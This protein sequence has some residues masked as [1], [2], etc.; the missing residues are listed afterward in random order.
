MRVAQNLL[1]KTVVDATPKAF[2]ECYLFVGAD[3]I[4]FVLLSA[5]DCVFPLLGYS[6]TDVFVT[7][8]M[9]E[10]ITSWIDGYQREIASVKAIGG[11][12]SSEVTREWNRLLQGGPKGRIEDTYV[13]PLLSSSWNQTRPYNNWCPEDAGNEDG[14]A[15]TG[16]VATATA[17]VMYYW[18]HPVQG[19]RSHSYMSQTYGELGVNYDTSFYDWDNMRNSVTVW[20]GQASV[21]AVAKLCY[22]VGV[23]MDMSYSAASSGA[24]EHSGGMLKRRSAQQGL[25]EH[26]YYN[27]GM[28]A[29]FKEGYTDAEWDTI[30][31]NELNAERPIIYTGSSSTG[32][33]AF[34][35][36]GYDPEGLFH[37]NWGW[38][39]S[40]N[41]YYTLNHLAVG[42]EGQQGYMAF[43]EL[44]G[45][46]LHCYPITP[47]DS[48]SVVSVVSSD[49]ARGS[50][51][52]SGIYPV[53]SDRVL[54]Y[55]TAADGYRF[56][57]W[58]SG[59]RNNPIMFFPTI[60]YSDTAYF[61]PLRTDSLGYCHNYAPN[62]DTLYSL[63]HCE[64]GI[65]IPADHLPAGKEL[66]QVMD[67]VYTTGNYILKI[68]RGE[69]PV[70]PVYEDT[71]LL[72]SYGWRT[73][74]LAT[75]VALDGDQPLWIT[76]ITEN[77]K[78]P[79]GIS[80]NSGVADGSWIKHDGNW[81]PMDTTD[82]GYYTWSILGLLRSPSGIESVVGDG[83][84]YTLDGLTLSIDNPSRRTVSLYDVSGRK[85]MALS[86]ERSTFTLPAPG[87][88]LIQADGLPAR[89]IVAVQR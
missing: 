57:H 32:G 72:T 68:Y 30:I 69:R 76:F 41:G 13:G 81:E 43:N 19:R 17:Q 85:H 74:D 39:G 62:F 66:A 55:A 35:I 28:F 52:G 27:P 83:L 80:P 8:N 23:I 3:G 36:D 84:V 31:S 1:Q 42:Q 88:Y 86:A 45:A 64:W 4:G 47:N 65:R 75:P 70:T 51:R 34:V 22:E 56:D 33:H 50:V 60:D 82:L 73:I 89:R 11:L 5:D 49:P 29:D 12:V 9:P 87:F 67:F 77:V 44:N 59:N 25:A 54:L 14:H 37:V 18:K 10:N 48:V 46:I 20:S 16:C 71:V 21:D 63:P 40:N 53:S 7:D 2:T 79:V 24:Y 78:Y 15:L 58:A 61:V 6:H 26:F 38:G